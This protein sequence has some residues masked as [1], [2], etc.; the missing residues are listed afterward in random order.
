MLDTN[1]CADILCENLLQWNMLEK[2]G[3]PPAYISFKYWFLLG[4]LAIQSRSMSHSSKYFTTPSM[5]LY[6]LYY[7]F[8]S[9]FVSPNKRSRLFFHQKKII[10]SL[11]MSH[12]LILT[13]MYTFLKTW[14]KIF[15]QFVNG[16]PLWVWKICCIVVLFHL[17]YQP[18]M[19]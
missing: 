17:F 16:N 14:S 4:G 1:N 5:F 19:H 3:F 8:H 15:L 12:F 18:G 11:Q 9:W 10:F 7:W 13:K 2:F 6:L